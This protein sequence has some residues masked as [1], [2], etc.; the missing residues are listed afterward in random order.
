MIL[1]F[2]YL[3]KLLLLP[4]NKLNIVFIQTVIKYVFLVEK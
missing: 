1:T 4:S 2:N 3:T